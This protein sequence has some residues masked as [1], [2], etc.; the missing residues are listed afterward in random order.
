M[1]QLKSINTA[2]TST[3][4]TETEKTTEIE[5]TT[6]MSLRF[7]NIKPTFAFYH[8]VNMA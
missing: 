6:D 4:T 1:K 7:S 3:E 2:T 8:N 5:K